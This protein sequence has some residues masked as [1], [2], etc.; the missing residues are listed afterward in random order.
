MPADRLTARLKKAAAEYK[1]TE[2]EPECN[3]HLPYNGLM[4]DCAEIRKHKEKDNG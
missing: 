3:V 1:L 4:C 2:H